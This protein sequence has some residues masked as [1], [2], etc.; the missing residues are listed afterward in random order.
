[1][2]R[3]LPLLFLFVACAGDP[4]DVEIVDLKTIAPDDGFTQVAEPYNEVVPRH[5]EL[6][7]KLSFR[8]DN[9]GTAR[10]A[11]QSRYV[12]NLPDLT[13]GD[14]SPATPVAITPGV[15]QDLEVQFL[16]EKDGQ[17][18]ILSAV[19]LN[20]NPVY[21]QQPIVA[22]NDKD[23]PLIYLPETEN[24]EVTDFRY[25]RVAGKE[26]FLSEEGLVNL[27]LPNL[28][29]EYFHLPKG[30]KTFTGW[31]TEAPAKTGYINRVDLYN[32]ADRSTD[33]AIRFTGTLNIPQAAEYYFKT[34]GSGN[35]ELLF[36][37]K[38][39]TNQAG[40]PNDWD[41]ADSLR[42][43]EGDHAFDLRIVQHHGWNVNRISYRKAG[44]DEDLRFLNAME[45]RKVIATPAATN[46]RKLET[47]EEPFLLR[48]F[49]F[50]P[51]PKLYEE[52]TKRTHVV[53]VG[54]GKGPHYSI[55][56][57]TGALLQVWRGD[58]ADVHDMW[59]GRGEPQAMRPLGPAIQFDGDMLVASSATDPWPGPPAAPDE[60]NF[61][62]VA[63]EL[64]E[65]GRPTF[66]YGDGQRS[67]TDHITPNQGGLFREITHTVGGNGTYFVQL[68]AASEITEVAPGEF[69]LRSPGHRIKI[70]SYDG[71][72]LT[73]QKDGNLQRLIAELPAKGHV[74]YQIDW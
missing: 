11:F 23:G 48:S 64:D 38:P 10:L 33:Y 18:A 36:D 63:H 28:R 71:S 6:T 25:A 51:S 37:G 69:D 30:R 31:E 47:D 24:L 67:I 61:N 57:Q 60:D 9:E 54:E 62:H 17:P 52:A 58:F 73:L 66:I 4:L 20:G 49:L 55:D 13:I 32:I 39:V 16:P 35:T 7:V 27:N 34:W 3:F 43:T 41:D 22:E 68:A 29:Y 8:T 59:D 72:G 44:S 40:A 19:Y 12:L 42:L 5:D 56:L 1:M 65:A 14:L 21:Y 53:S 26:S 70:E 50:F 74:R 15:W 46:P 45:E 2:L